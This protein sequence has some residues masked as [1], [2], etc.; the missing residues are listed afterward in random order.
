MGCSYN[1]TTNIITVTG[2]TEESPCGF[3][4]L[5]DADIGASDGRQL[6]DGTIDADPDTFSLDSQPKSADD[7]AVPLKIVCTARG[8]ATCDI[9]GKDAWGNALSE[10][11][12]N[13][14]SGTAT[15]TERFSEIDAGGITVN[16]LQNGDDFDIYQDRWGVVW[17]CSE[18]EYRL[19]CMILIDGAYF[20]DINKLVVITDNTCLATGNKVFEINNSGH[21][22]FGEVEDE[23]LKTGKHGCN[24]V[25]LNQS[26]VNC[27]IVR[28]GPTETA[29]F[30]SCKFEG[31]TTSGGR[32]YFL[33][34]A[35]T[36]IWDCQVTGYIE[37]RFTLSSVDVYNFFHTG[38][39]LGAL[40][41]SGA[42]MEKIYISDIAYDVFT[43]DK[44]Y[45]CIWKNVTIGNYGRRLFILKGIDEHQY[46]I[47]LLLLSGDDEWEV[48]FHPSF[49]STAYLYRQHTFNL[50]TTP[51]AEVVLED[52][53]GNEVFSETADENGVIS[54]Q[55]VSRGYYAQATGSTLQELGPFT[56]TISKTG[57]QTY[58]D[59][60]FVLNEK[61]DLEI[62]LQEQEY[63][64]VPTPVNEAAIAVEVENAV[65]IVVA[66]ENEIN[67]AVEV[68]Q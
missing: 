67:I 4:D 48:Y 50:T 9:S 56:L 68:E 21:I 59:D 3:S 1:Q 16:G 45:Q 30:Y 61:K 54:E 42:T 62:M 23:A 18:S 38:A 19:D 40:N 29:N 31:P 17:E 47:D 20:K 8:G 65:N 14:S 11:G 44:Y 6:L 13:I 24:I 57:Y 28:A 66:V 2:Y 37:C 49:E 33:I 55:T 60:D 41:Y 43:T 52:K 36:R 7:L 25:W 53:D 10:N 27:Y 39:Y 63:V 22:E 58:E 26:Y 64:Y 32:G 46:A 5:Y 12:I 35:N 34:S 15:T 51:G